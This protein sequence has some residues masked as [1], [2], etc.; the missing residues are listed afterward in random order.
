MY[1]VCIWIKSSSRFQLN[2]KMI[3]K[4]ILQFF[5]FVLSIGLLGEIYNEIKAVVPVVF[6]YSVWT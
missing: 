2:E 6:F 4:N 1:G 3:R 5:A